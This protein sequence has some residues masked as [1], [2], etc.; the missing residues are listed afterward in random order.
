MPATTSGTGAPLASWEMTSLSANTVQV[1]EISAG[2]SDCAARPP[3]ASTSTFKIPAITSRNRPVPAAHLSFI[4]KPL[5][6]PDSSKEM[7]LAS[8]PPMSMTVRASGIRKWQPR[9]WALSSLISPPAPAQRFL[10]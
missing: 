7:T 3:R 8:W 1:L 2:V 5:M 4:T 9:A 10:P 6:R